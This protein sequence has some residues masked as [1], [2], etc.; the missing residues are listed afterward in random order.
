VESAAAAYRLGYAFEQRFLADNIVSSEMIRAI[1]TAHIVEAGTYRWSLREERDATLDPR[2]NDYPNDKREIIQ[3]GL[4][5]A[6]ELA[7]KHALTPEEAMFICPEGL[8]ALEIKVAEAK[9]VV[10]EL[11]NWGDRVD[12]LMALHGA[13][14]DGLYQWLNSFLEEPREWPA[15]IAPQE[16]G[17]FG[18]AEGW[19]AAFDENGHILRISQIRQPQ[20][21]LAIEAWFAK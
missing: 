10:E 20:P 8:A 6:K 4:A 2:L 19:L 5:M 14:I 18:Y 13:T 15:R 7:P 16:G 21:E 17:I 9:E 3:V 1:R 11:A 12:H